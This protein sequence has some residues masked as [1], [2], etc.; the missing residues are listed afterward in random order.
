MDDLIR[1]IDS[2]INAARKSISSDTIRFVNIDS[3]LASPEL[4]APFGAGARRVLDTVVKMGKSE[5]F[6]TEEYDNVGVVSLA[7]K[8]GQPDL[9]IWLHGDVVAVG[10]GWSFEPFNAVEYEGCVIGRGAADNKGQLAAMFNLLKIFKKL[11]VE[12][13]Y[14]PAIYVGSNEENGV[15]DVLGDKNIP[16]ALGFIN[17]ATPPRLSLIPD[18]SFP[19]CYG[20]KGKMVYRLLS[21]TRFSS[22]QFIAGQDNN[23]WKA[24]AVFEEGV[25]LPEKLNGCSVEQ[26]GRTFWAESNPRHG[27]SPDPQGNM[28]TKLSLALLESGLVPT[29]NV[30]VLEAF[31]ELTRD[32]E[33]VALGIYKSHPKM[34]T[35]RVFV[36]KV[37]F[38]NGFPEIELAIRFHVGMTPEEMTESIKD[39]ADKNGFEL[40]CAQKVIDPYMNNPDTEYVKVLCEIANSQTGSTA[41]P[42]TISGITYANTLPNAYPYGASSNA[43]PKSFEKG[44]GT[45]HGIDE[46]VSLDALQRAMRIY[47]RALLRLNEMEW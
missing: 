24:Y 41:A 2:E 8:E 15:R 9:G 46:S 3:R 1:K 44:K 19:I 5:G 45:V 20:G 28:V 32:P 34:G 39:Y 4:G 35:P 40:T 18:S 12:L 7:L 30:E 14:N 33:G 6:Y 16:G 26:D 25:T 47:A 17:V 29:E 27:S 22:F 37:D 10:D 38:V 42:Y 31:A 23:P 36:S 21:K 13:R 43:A 11:G